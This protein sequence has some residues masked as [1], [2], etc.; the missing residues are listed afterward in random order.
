MSTADS[1]RQ[2]WIDWQ[3]HRGLVESRNRWRSAAFVAGSL[4]VV[5]AGVAVGNAEMVER[6]NG[7]T[8]DA[9][10]IATK[11]ID[12]ANTAVDQRN[13]AIAIARN[14]DGDGER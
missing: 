14:C 13:D 5:I 10:D 7:R 4:A 6:A 8:A 2:D 1:S 9:F 11:A 12:I 3:N